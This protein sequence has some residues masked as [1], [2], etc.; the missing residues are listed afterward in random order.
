MIKSFS[1]NKF[2]YLIA[3][4]IIFLNILFFIGINNISAAEPPPGGTTY[5]TPSKS[6]G[7]YDPLGGQTITSLIQN[8]IGFLIKIGAPIVALMVLYGGFLILTA[9]DK[10][11]QITKGK[12]TILYAAIGYTIILC[13]WGVI[14]IIQQVLGAKL[15]K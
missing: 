15:I 5:T 9:G 11:E 7:L 2:L 13:S 6:G 1:G 8:L 12:N 4:F 3:I 14:Y 10:P